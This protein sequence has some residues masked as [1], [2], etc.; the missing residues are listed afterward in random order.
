MGIISSLVDVF[1]PPLCLACKARCATKFLCP[2][3]WLRC[4]LPDPVERCRHCFEEL[5][6]R[7]EL[8]SSCRRKPLLPVPRAYV[9]DPASPAR[10]LGL[11][12]VDALSSFALIQWY[13]L[14]WEIPDVIIPMPDADSISIGRSF[15]VALDAPFMR[16]LHLDCEIKEN[17]LEEEQTLLLFDVSN[18]MEKLVKASLALS[19]SFPKRIYLLSLIPYADPFS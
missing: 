6:Q 12:A 10:F 8:C 16:A 2:E 1:F 11:E 5:D 9:F 7:G 18:R 4:E 14:D 13:K 17:I 3:C 15:A 19:E